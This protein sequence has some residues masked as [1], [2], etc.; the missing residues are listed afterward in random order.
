M[1]VG[2]NPPTDGEALWVDS[3]EDPPPTPVIVDWETVTDKPTSFP[4]TIANVDGLE[5]ALAAAG[6]GDWADAIAALNAAAA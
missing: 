2:P 4:S 3:Y 5:D 1:H 6:E